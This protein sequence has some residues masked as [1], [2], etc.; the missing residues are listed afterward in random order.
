MSFIS[1]EAKK[2][3]SPVGCM[4]GRFTIKVINGEGTGLMGMGGGGGLGYTEW[5]ALEWGGWGVEVS[6]F[7]LP[8]PPPLLICISF[9]LS[10]FAIW[11]VCV[12]ACVGRLLPVC[13]RSYA[14]KLRHGY[15][16]CE[17][18]CYRGPTIFYDQSQIFVPYIF[19]PTFK[20]HPSL[21][22]RFI[23]MFQGQVRQVKAP[24]PRVRYKRRATNDYQISSARYIR[25]A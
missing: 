24:M 23:E 8:P 4:I 19:H 12:W 14:T 25:T 1:I 21:L 18:Y 13:P 5:N 3:I 6:N 20:S 7:S 10:L 15:I 16:T 9:S 2:D 11:W 22:N 17:T